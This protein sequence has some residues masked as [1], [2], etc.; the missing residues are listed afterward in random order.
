MQSLITV[1][2]LQCTGQLVLVYQL[3]LNILPYSASIWQMLPTTPATALA[4]QHQPQQRASQALMNASHM[5][6]THAHTILCTIIA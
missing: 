1:L 2:S 5:P 6:L 3:V 4:C